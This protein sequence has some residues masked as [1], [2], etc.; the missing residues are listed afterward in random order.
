M[1]PLS[2]V[3]EPNFLRYE[4]ACPLSSVPHPHC[5]Y[6]DQSGMWAKTTIGVLDFRC[7]TS[8]SIH[9]SCSPPSV[10]RPPAL[11]FI[12]FTRPIKWTPFLSKLYQPCPLEFFP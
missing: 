6:T 8:S 5:G 12:T 11:R 1:C 10:P 9:S 2:T 7:L 4:S 3:T